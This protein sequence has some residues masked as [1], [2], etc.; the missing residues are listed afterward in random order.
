MNLEISTQGVHFCEK[1]HILR[2]LTILMSDTFWS[3]DLKAMTTISQEKSNGERS[4][5]TLLINIS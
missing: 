4:N 1:P 2:S 3:I 5:I